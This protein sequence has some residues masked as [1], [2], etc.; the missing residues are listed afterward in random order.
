MERREKMEETMIKEKDSAKAK[1]NH[2]GTIKVRRYSKC[3]V[4]G[5]NI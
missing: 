1:P 2:V 4:V 5:A 3:E